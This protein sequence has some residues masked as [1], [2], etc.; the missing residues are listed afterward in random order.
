MGGI[1]QFLNSPYSF[2]ALLALPSVG[3]MSAFL[4]GG[5][6][7]HDLL[8]PTG[9]FAARF[10]ILA[11]V[12]TPL[13]ML[14]ATHR[15]PLW[16]VCRRRYLGVAAFGY[17]LLHTIFYVVDLGSV[18][19]VLSDSLKLS[20][21]TGWV[22]FLI[23]VPLALTS[24]DWAMRRMKQAWKPLQRWVY[25]AA[26]MTLGHWIFLEYELGPALVHFLPLIALETY[27]VVRHV[28][29]SRKPATA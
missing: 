25:V 7:P 2:W 8:H 14:F 9:E 11:M 17:A 13:R 22:A 20:I 24:N 27:R 18:S 26:G 15:W 6:S 28:Q 23:F 5:A 16:L 12:I 29:Q 10:M 3:M 21:W 1:V 4:S 19:A